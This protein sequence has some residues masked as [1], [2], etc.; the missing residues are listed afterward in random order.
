MKFSYS[1]FLGNQPSDVFVFPSDPIGVAAANFK[2]GACGGQRGRGE[3]PALH[4]K[5][6]Y[7]SPLPTTTTTK[8]TLEGRIFLFFSPAPDFYL[9]C[10]RRK[11][12]S[13]RGRREGGSGGVIC[14]D[15]KIGKN[16]PFSHSPERLLPSSPGDIGKHKKRQT[17]EGGEEYFCRVRPWHAHKFLST[18]RNCSRKIFPCCPAGFVKKKNFTQTLFSRIGSRPPSLPFFPLVIVVIPIYIYW[19]RDSFQHMLHTYEA[20]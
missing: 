8:P 10:P 11:T 6:V 3:G 1:L 17:E 13:N 9:H 12:D 18:S 19:T 5:I 2:R 14:V 15:H 16:L 4:S 20:Q 7:K